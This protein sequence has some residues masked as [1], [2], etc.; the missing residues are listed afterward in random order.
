MNSS[1]W[2]MAFRNQSMKISAAKK[3]DICGRPP[4]QR[5]TNYQ[6]AGTSAPH[7]LSSRSRFSASSTSDGARF[8]S[9][10]II[11]YLV[12]YGQETSATF[13]NQSACK[14]RPCGG[15]QRTPSE[16]PPLGRPL[17]TLACPWARTR[18]TPCTWEEG[19]GE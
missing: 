1:L 10:R 16:W 6:L 3:N 4:G 7:R 19:Y 17:G 2:W 14:R 5:T 12:P 11:Q 8:S 18:R 13:C 9:S 15:C